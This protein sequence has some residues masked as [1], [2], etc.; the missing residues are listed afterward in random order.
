MIKEVQPKKD[1]KT[2]EEYTAEIRSLTK[3]RKEAKLNGK[4]PVS[5]S[6]FIGFSEKNKIFK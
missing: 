1:L 4:E 6:K 3:L 2:S 5:F